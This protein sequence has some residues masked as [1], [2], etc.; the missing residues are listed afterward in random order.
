MIAI[1]S[2]SLPYIPRSETS[3]AANNSTT[4]MPETPKLPTFLNKK[5]RNEEHSNK[6]QQAEH[7]SD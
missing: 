6:R 1:T 5:Q 7:S 2:T 3:Y 4:R